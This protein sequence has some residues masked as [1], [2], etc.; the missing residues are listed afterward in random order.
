MVF[1]SVFWSVISDYGKRVYVAA[2][3]NWLSD[4]GYNGFGE[5][6]KATSLMIVLKTVIL[7]SLLCSEN[8]EHLQTYYIFV[9]V[10]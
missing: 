6:S 1:L 10:L 4:F 8:V 2:F 9:P 5:K 3:M 7:A